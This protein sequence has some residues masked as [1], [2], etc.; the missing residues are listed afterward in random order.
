MKKISI[1]C[2]ISCLLLTSC[3]T[4][5]QYQAE[6]EKIHPK[7]V[8]MVGCL[9]EKL[10]ADSRSQMAGNQPYVQRYL[11]E[12]DKLTYMVQDNEISEIDAR[13]RLSDLYMQLRS[14]QK[15]EVQAAVNSWQ[16]Q[17]AINNMNKPVNTSCHSTG[18]N[19][20]CQ[21]Y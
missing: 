4:A 6:C 12:A 18:N 1:T 16:R 20:H 13:I 19:I 2:I 5:G 14:S 15:T 17:Q 7:F 3:A 10:N 9:K 8:N 11:L 21:E